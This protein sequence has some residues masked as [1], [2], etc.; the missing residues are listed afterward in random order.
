MIE[1]SSTKFVNALAFSNGMA[2]LT[3]KNP[4]PLVPSCLI[5]TCDATGP[6]A[7]SWSAPSTVFAVTSPMNGIRC[8]DQ[9]DGDDDRQRQRVNSVRVSC[10]KLPRLE[11]VRLMIP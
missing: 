11:L 7:R 4:P 10:Q 9:E 3:L 1:S 8:R 2:E 5:A 6:T